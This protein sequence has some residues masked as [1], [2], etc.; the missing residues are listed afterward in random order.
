MSVGAVVTN[1]EGGSKGDGGKPRV[2]LLNPAWL[3][4]TAEVLSHGARKYGVENWRKVEPQRYRDAALRHLLEYLAGIERDGETG[5]HHLAHLHCSIM[6]LWAFDQ[7]GL[8][9]LSAHCECT[10]CANRLHGAT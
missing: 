4:E 7:Q 1:E 10:V 5:L 2:S 8:E 9:A 6:F 3:W